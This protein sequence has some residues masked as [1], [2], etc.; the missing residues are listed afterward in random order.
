MSDRLA[1][2][3]GFSKVN[4]IGPARL[5]NLLDYFGDIEIAWQANPGELA[6]I[7]LPKQSIENLVKMRQTLDLEKELAR[8]DSLSV[9]ILIWDD[10]NYPPL[11]RTI[12]DAPF[13][14]YIRG[15]LLPCDE[16]AVAV[17]GTRNAS[18]YG[19]EVTRRLVNGLVSNGVT[20]V[21]GLAL[22][23]DTAAHQA[24][25]DAGG[26]TI[27]V[28]GNGVDVIYPARNQKLSDQIVSNGALISE[29]P[30]GR[31]PEGGNF[32]RRN[33]IISA[34][35]LGVLMVEG[36]EKS[37]AKITV[38]FA[39]EQGRE[40]FAVPGNVGSRGSQG[41]NKLIQQG[42]KLVTCLNDILEELNL[43]MIPEQKE[44]KAIIPD[45]PTEAT[46]LEHLSVEPTHIDELG[47]STGLPAAALSSTLVIMELKGQ[48][49]HVGS[50]HYVMARETQTQYVV[51]VPEK[52]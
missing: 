9:D 42:A 47:Q 32:P 24:A 49:R 12:S 39:L 20:I 13:I 38:D 26:R 51:D 48:I 3:I 15:D 33:R 2:W 22:G 4:G 19:K 8:L 28:L 30:L 23:I 21:S 45:T 14:L 5:R 35:S 11:L 17:V 50:M 6:A 27:A 7:G 18:M 41:P 25:L 43:T 34:L 36:G 10:E 46:I 16:W 40:V 52:K 29:F 44:A 37:G 31:H 1:Y